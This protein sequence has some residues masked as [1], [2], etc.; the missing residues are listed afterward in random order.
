M[1]NLLT[2]FFFSTITSNISAQYYKIDLLKDINPGSASSFPYFLGKVDATSIYFA[3]DDG[4]HGREPWKSNGTSNGTQM[5]MDINNVGSN[6]SNP[7]GFTTLIS[8]VFSFNRYV[9]FAADDGTNGDELWRSQ[10]FG[11]EPFTTQLLKDINPTGSSGPR[12]LTD[13]NGLLMFGATNGTNGREFW[14]SNGTSA[15]TS[16]ILDYQLGGIDIHI[17][18]GSIVPIGNSAFF[19]AVDNS[20]YLLEVT[21]TTISLVGV[22]DFSAS[23]LSANFLTKVN[24]NLFF[25]GEAYAPS[26]SKGRE[27]FVKPLG[28]N[29]FLLKDINVGTNSSNPNNLTDVNGTL[30]F[31]AYNGTS[32]GIWKSDGTIAGTQIVKTIDARNLCNVNG[33]LFFHSFNG[34]QLQLWKSDGTTTGTVLVKTLN[35]YN[36]VLN[37]GTY[38][39]FNGKFIFESYSDTYGSELWQ[40]DGTAAGTFIIKDINPNSGSSTPGNLTVVNNTLY[41]TANNGILGAELYKMYNCFGPELNYTTKNGNWSDPTVWSCGRVPVTTEAVTIKGHTININGNFGVNGILFEGGNITIPTGST[42]TYYQTSP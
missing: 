12:V 32:Y 8:E 4:Q 40:S 3:A 20:S 7:I 26:N 42:L 33:T 10:I 27:L 16:M 29:A 39:N 19:S 21:S 13:V 31:T 22:N 24:N 34:N 37:A 25:S 41:F 23:S 35:N 30:F 15:G 5:V 36:N 2:I 17:T 14:K 18:P 1:K 6:S 38:V 28:Q 9:Y 11:N